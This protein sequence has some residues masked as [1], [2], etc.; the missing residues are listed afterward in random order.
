VSISGTTAASIPAGPEVLVELR[1][2][3]AAPLRAQLERG[4]RD[5]VRAGCLPAGSPLPSSRALA[6]DLAVSRRLVVEAYAQLTAE[7][8]LSARRGAGT[9]VAATATASPVSAP[10]SE[11]EPEAPRFDFF[12]GAPDLGGFPRA[13][14]LRAL[15]DALRTAP[16]H[17]LGYPDSRGTAAL[18]A[19]LA[20][21]LRRT[22][23]V[24]AEPE[25]VVVCTGVT[26]ALALL[27]G[28]LAARGTPRVAVEDPSLPPHRAVL[29]A[30]GAE[31]LPVPV[32]GDGLRL[33]VLASPRINADAVVVTPAHQFPTGVAL[34]A[35]R[36]GELLAWAA[37]GR[38]VIEDD[39]DAPFRYDRAPIGALQGLAPDSVAYVGSASKTLA[40]GLR[41]GWL[42]LPSSL[43]KE[44]STAKLL[45]DGGSPVLDQLALARMLA[46]GAYDRHLRGARRRYRA[47]RDALLASLAEHLPGARVGGIA[48][49][50]HAVLSPPEVVES[51]ALLAAAR[52]HSLGVYALDARGTLLLGYANL[53]EPAI[54]EGVRRLAEA[55]AEC[56]PPKVPS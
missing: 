20:S 5:A 8:Y 21:H 43:V 42:V 52:R 16:D 6:R 28:V 55:F 7:G 10:T 9:V 49:G 25:R 34:S 39:Y 24:A 50:L 47:R 31:V 44:V 22:R 46:T 1:R 40:P 2:G 45:A 27:A 18:R 56:S 51:R 4:L 17:E 54:A 19:E 37:E 35:E 3:D 36:R 12:P 15:R 23:G 53:S 13:A 26:Q 32:D 29:S 41:L 30:H 11:A 14:W 38:L 48:A 33:A